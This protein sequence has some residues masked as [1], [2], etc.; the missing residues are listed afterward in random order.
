MEDP[1][2]PQHASGRE[3]M[4]VRRE[5]SGVR[6]LDF[7]FLQKHRLDNRKMSFKA[8]FIF[9]LIA[10]CA[11]KAGRAQTKLIPFNSSRIY[12]EGRIP[13]DNGAAGLAWPGTSATLIFKGTTISALLEDR[14]TANYYNVI[15][16]GKVVNKIQTDPRKRNYVL[17]SDL[18]PGK[19]RVE[20]FKRTEAAMGKTLFYGFETDSHAKIYPKARSKKRKIEF[21][22]NS[23]TCGYADEDSIGDAG[24]GYVENGY[25]SYAAITAR[26]F[27]AAFSSIS[28]SGIGIMLSWFPVIMPEMYDRLDPGDST[29]KWDFTQYRP[30]VVELPLYH[31]G[32]VSPRQYHLRP[33]QHGCHTGRRTLA[34]V[35]HKSS[36]GTE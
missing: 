13:R 7:H 20:L 36:S 8:A 11:M 35:H 3:V 1:R 4:F 2:N 28:K 19:H 32:Q 27:N 24:L 31:K 25:L 34:G 15:V 6:V 21:Y 14:D 29:S 9:P 5:S 12:Y 26:H 10:I 17:A 33:R 16:D 30:D 18:P 23:I 22:G